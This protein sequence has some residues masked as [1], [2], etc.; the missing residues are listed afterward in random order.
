[1]HSEEAEQNFCTDWEDKPRQE[2][3]SL[4]LIEPKPFSVDDK[5]ACED[6]GL[7]AVLSSTS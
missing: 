7:G 6:N 4:R 3:L 2:V 1:M 5:N